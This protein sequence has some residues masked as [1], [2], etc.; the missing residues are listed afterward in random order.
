MG[1]LVGPSSNLGVPKLQDMFIKDQFYIY[2]WGKRSN[3]YTIEYLLWVSDM[4]ALDEHS[5]WLKCM[6]WFCLVFWYLMVQY[7]DI[8]DILESLLMM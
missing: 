4:Y 3:S 2:T 1:C 7:M 6:M 5:N 8:L